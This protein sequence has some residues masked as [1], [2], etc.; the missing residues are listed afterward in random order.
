MAD[1]LGRQVFD[2]VAHLMVKLVAQERVDELDA[3]ALLST[4]IDHL[5]Q[6]GWQDQQESLGEFRNIGFVVTAFSVNGLDEYMAAR[7]DA[8]PKTDRAERNA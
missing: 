6:A 7:S 2:P 1:N 4:L 8:T 5:A 3:I